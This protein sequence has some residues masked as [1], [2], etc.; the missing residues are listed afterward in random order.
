MIENSPIQ[1]V[2]MRGD[3]TFHELAQLLHQ[4]RKQVPDLKPKPKYHDTT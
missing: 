1:P 3:F 4:G 2:G